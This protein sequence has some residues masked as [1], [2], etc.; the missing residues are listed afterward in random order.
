MTASQATEPHTTA[1]R[2]TAGGATTAANATTTTP[3]PYLTE[4]QLA[5]RWQ[6]NPGSLANA[7]GRGRNV[8][9]YIKLLGS[10]VRYPLVLVEAYEAA[11]LA[12]AA[13]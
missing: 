8:V 12:E 7:R 2:L 9:G 6:V 1:N 5:E 11:L 3:G 10:R 13:A 4:N